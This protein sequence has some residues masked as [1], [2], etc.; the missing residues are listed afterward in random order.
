[1]TAPDRV[2]IAV[3]GLGFGARMVDL[4]LSPP[5][6]ELFE[7]VAVCDV[8]SYRLAEVAART[9]LRG[10]QSLDALL[11][12]EDVVAVGLFTGP[13][14]RAGLVR[15]II[16]SGRHVLTTKPFELDADAAREV[17]AEA[18][19]FKRVVHLNSPAP[20][21]PA[22]L[23]Q[24]EQWREQYQLG[25]AVAGRGEVWTSYFEEADGGWYD[26]PERCPVAPVLR[27]GIYLINDLVRLFGE[28]EAVQVTCSRLRTGRPTPDNAQIGIRF[29]NGAI[30]N[31][32]ASFCVDDGRR[33]N[34]LL[35]LNYTGGTIS[36]QSRAVSP[37]GRTNLSV[38]AGAQ[39][40]GSSRETTATSG[41]SGDYE[42]DAFHRAV[43]G[44]GPP[45]VKVH[46]QV[47]AGLRIVEAMARAERSGCTEDVLPA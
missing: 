19:A 39:L 8:D 45:D 31:V 40:G 46:H 7:L 25:E 11:D 37:V 18:R 44:D 36:R 30:G 4:L 21:L 47:V 6:N 27:L 34:S 5:A 3:V 13:A 41:G 16:Q 28:A 10:C 42:W 2:P 23:R 43:R 24:I 9:G 35:T 29:R 26:D 22:D 20:V 32:F 15:K 33:F 38:V 12:T 1:M 17:L 14:G